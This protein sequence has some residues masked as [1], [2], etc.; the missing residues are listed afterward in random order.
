MNRIK[1]GRNK[2]EARTDSS[3][4]KLGRKNTPREETKEEKCVYETKVVHKHIVDHSFVKKWFPLA[5]P[6]M[7]FLLVSIILFV[8]A[9]KNTQKFKSRYISNKLDVTKI[10]QVCLD[11]GDYEDCLTLTE[12]KDG[13]LFVIKE[14]DGTQYIV[15]RVS[16]K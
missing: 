8:D 2:K 7:I 13:E 12:Y 16:E 1:L 15:V 11:R 3:Q 6:I 4:I 14:K 5:I 10:K 9:S